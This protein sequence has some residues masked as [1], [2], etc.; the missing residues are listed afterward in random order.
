MALVPCVQCRQPFYA[1]CSDAACVDALCPYCA[2]AE[3]LPEDSD[4]AAVSGSP[5]GPAAQEAV[6]EEVT[7]GHPAPL[8]APVA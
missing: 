6:A 5:H 2:Y 4:G 7:R 3:L 8:R 1:S